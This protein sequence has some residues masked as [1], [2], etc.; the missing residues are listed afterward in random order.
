MIFSDEINVNFWKEVE[1][2]A[3]FDLLGPYIM[4]E[5]PENAILYGNFSQRLLESD[6][7]TENDLSARDLR[8]SWVVSRSSKIA[9]ELK[10]NFTNPVDISTL[11]EGP[12]YMSVRF[13]PNE[14]F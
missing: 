10:L 14:A 2:T 7:P 9:V 13:T 8:F 11:L 3:P 4:P 12:D 5:D 1:G 6:T